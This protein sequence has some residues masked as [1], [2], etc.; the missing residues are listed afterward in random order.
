MSNEN[1]ER[2]HELSQRDGLVGLPLIG[3]FD[4]INEDDEIFILSLVMSLD[5]LCFS[6]SHD[7][8]L[9]ELKLDGCCLWNEG[10]W[11]ELQVLLKS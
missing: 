3:F 9:V 10:L 4:V 8:V 2:A 1:L 5:L 7:D 11:R 6:A